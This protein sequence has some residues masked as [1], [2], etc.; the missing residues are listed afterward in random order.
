MRGLLVVIGKCADTRPVV[1][2]EQSLSLSKQEE[3]RTG[4]MHE[5]PRPVRVLAL[6]GLNQSVPSGTHGGVGGWL[7]N[8][9]VALPDYSGN[10]GFPGQLFL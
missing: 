1:V 10:E 2:A 7:R 5:H 3:T 4:G 9:W 6:M 8:Q